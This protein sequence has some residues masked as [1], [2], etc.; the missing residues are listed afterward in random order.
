MELIPW[1]G[2]CQRCGKATG[3]HI[4]SMYSLRLVCFDCKKSEQRR[5][6]YRKAT[7]AETAACLAGDFSFAGIGEPSVS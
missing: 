1:D 5:P 6:D 4:M 2:H 7:D 3:S